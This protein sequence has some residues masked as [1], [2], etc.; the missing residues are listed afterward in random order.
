MPL[1]LW[2]A[3]V[4]AS[5]ALLMMPGPTVMVVVGY[6]LSHGRRSAWPSVSGLVLGDLTA[7][8]VSLAGLGAVLATSALAFTVLKWVGAVYL[9]YLGIKSWRSA[10]TTDTEVME[11]ALDGPPRIF[12]RAFLVTAMNPKSIAFFIAFLPQFVSHGAPALPQFVA[13]GATFL[14]L[15]LVNG[16]VYAWLASGVRRAVLSG[17]GLRNVRRVGGGCL[18]GA[19]LATATM[20][21]G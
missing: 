20:S 3:F 13:L 1:D 6:A 4:V 11:P 2:L 14:A 9:I 16:V 5:T 12:L 10:G 17:R 15:A 19:G 8:T 21:R 7:M 18:I